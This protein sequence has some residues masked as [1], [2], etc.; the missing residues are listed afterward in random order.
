[1]SKNIADLGSIARLYRDGTKSI[2]S[3]ITE[4]T[5]NDTLKMNQDDMK[6]WEDAG[7]PIHDDDFS[8]DMESIKY[9]LWI[10]SRRAGAFFANKVLLV[11]GPTE[12]ALF[13]YMIDNGFIP[14]PQEGIYVIDT[15]GKFNTHRFMNLFGA[16]GIPHYILIDGDKGKYEIVDETIRSS[17]NP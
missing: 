11:E 2:V 15:I 12:T 1:M 6:S 3:Q 5:I 4:D 17:S 16:L 7:I 9:A 10:D 8:I 13:N 14:S